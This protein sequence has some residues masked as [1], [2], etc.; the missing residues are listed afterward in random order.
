MFFFFLIT[1]ISSTVRKAIVETI[2]FVWGVC[3]GGTNLCES[4]AN[5][6]WVHFYKL[7]NCIW[8]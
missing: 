5:T 7:E 8:F 3:V 4:V 1:G 6:Y 2:R